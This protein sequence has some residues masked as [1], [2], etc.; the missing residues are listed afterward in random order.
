[1]TVVEPTTHTYEN[2]GARSTID[3]A[4]SKG[5]AIVQVQCSSSSPGNSKHCMVVYD[6]KCELS[7]RMECNAA[8]E[9]MPTPSPIVDI[10]GKNAIKLRTKRSVFFKQHDLISRVKDLILQETEEGQPS[11]AGILREV[12]EIERM[13]R[14]HLI[15]C[16][17]RARHRNEAM[18]KKVIRRDMIGTGKFGKICREIKR[19]YRSPPSATATKHRREEG[20][21]VEGEAEAGNFMSKISRGGSVVGWCTDDGAVKVL[22]EDTTVKILIK[23]EVHDV[24]REEWQQ[25]ETAGGTLHLKSGQ[26][27]VQPDHR[28]V[29]CTTDDST[30]VAG[31][32]SDTYTEWFAPHGSEWWTSDECFKNMSHGVPVIYASSRYDDEHGRILYEA[33]KQRREQLMKGDVTNINDPVIIPSGMYF[34]VP[35]HP[36]VLDMLKMYSRDE[37]VEPLALWSIP[38]VFWS[39]MRSKWAGVASARAPL[40]Y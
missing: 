25:L 8:G 24:V 26:L 6:F 34:A 12:V 18:E 35:I 11:H 22:L 32:I 28:L 39:R 37:G 27:L 29:A 7:L 9:S 1:M 14:L 38:K 30:H 13:A 15:K 21:R 31:L 20:L 2:A 17:R 3:W 19:D 23:G 33:G 36:M 16:S 4:A 10:N 5:G 40:G